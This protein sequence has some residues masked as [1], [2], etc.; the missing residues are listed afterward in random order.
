[1]RSVGPCH[2]IE[3][4]SVFRRHSLFYSFGRGVCRFFG[5]NAH[6]RAVLP[7]VIAAV[8]SPVLSSVPLIDK[9]VII[10]K[11]LKNI[12]KSIDFFEIYA[13]IGTE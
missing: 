2:S 6:P 4:A 8:F 12:N 10:H 13:I 7:A 11:S 3:S 1:M 5:R 9:Y